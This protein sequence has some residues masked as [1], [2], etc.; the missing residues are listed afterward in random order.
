MMGFLLTLLLSILIGEMNAISYSPMKCQEKCLVDYMCRTWT[1]EN[2]SCATSLQR[3]VPPL[4]FRR[5]GGKIIGGRRT[6]EKVKRDALNA[7]QKSFELLSKSIPNTNDC[8]FLELKENLLTIIKHSNES[9]EEIQSIDSFL[10]LNDELLEDIFLIQSEK[11]RNIEVNIQE[12]YQ[13]I[14]NF[15]RQIRSLKQKENDIKKEMENAREDLNRHN[16]YSLLITFLKLLVLANGEEP[17]DPRFSRKDEVIKDFTEGVKGDIKTSKTLEDSVT[18]LKSTV[19][20]IEQRINNLRSSQDTLE[21]QLATL[22]TE[23]LRL[24][25]EKVNTENEMNLI[26]SMKKSVVSVHVLLESI[27]AGLQYS[28][29]KIGSDFAPSWTFEEFEEAVEEVFI[30]IK[31]VLRT[32]ITD[33]N[34]LRERGAEVSSSAGRMRSVIKKCEQDFGRF[35]Q[36]ED[37]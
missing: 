25:E 14:N 19:H 16:G 7:F 34:V 24:K 9:V 17:N 18:E 29:R 26:G 28:R 22:K 15:N 27:N 20:E 2:H 3:A 23:I 35:F 4:Y 37:M 10:H 13:Q 32:M 6:T 21:K 11:V 5:E 36:L 1:V 31:E 33:S 30:G 8:K 12:N